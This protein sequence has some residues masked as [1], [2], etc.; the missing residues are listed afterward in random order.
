MF[1]KRR[2]IRSLKAVYIC[3]ASKYVDVP[4]SKIIDEYATRS[5]VE[6]RY[7]S[8]SYYVDAIKEIEKKI[9]ELDRRVKEI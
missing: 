7:L 2:Q 9:V 6:D 4:F 8:C 5:C 1:L 3:E